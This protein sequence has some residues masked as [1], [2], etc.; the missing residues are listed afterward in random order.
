MN[1]LSTLKLN[2]DIDAV[3]AG[4][5]VEITVEDTSTDEVAVEMAEK[6]DKKYIYESPDGGN[7]IYRR[8][9]GKDDREKIEKGL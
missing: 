1:I 7:T 6:D 4:T 2:A 5:G 9:F 8:E 3:N